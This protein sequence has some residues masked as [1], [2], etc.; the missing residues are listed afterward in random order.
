MKK[1]KKQVTAREISKLVLNE[2]VDTL[3][4]LV[5]NGMET[6]KNPW[7]RMARGEWEAYN[8][9]KE[10]YDAVRYAKQ[11]EYL[12]VR[13]KGSEIYLRLT[14]EGYERQLKDIILRTREQMPK[15]TVLIVAYDIPEVTRGVRAALR[16]LL[17]DAE[18]AQ[19]QKSVWIGTRDIERPLVA[20]IK[21]LGAQDYVDVYVGERRL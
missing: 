8:R 12:Q 9:Q 20:L 15:G 5:R 18:F 19:S 2:F 13:K 17:V 3:D 7:T 11:M 21:K 14:D 4:M 1:K 10:I 6:Y 16:R